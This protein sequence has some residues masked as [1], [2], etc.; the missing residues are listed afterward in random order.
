MS[1]SR[2]DWY[3]LRCSYSEKAGEM[4]IVRPPDSLAPR[5][6]SCGSPGHAPLMKMYPRLPMA[7]P[8]LRAFSCAMGSEICGPDAD[9]MTPIFSLC[10]ETIWG[11][12]RRGCS[13]CTCVI[14]VIRIR[15]NCLLTGHR[16]SLFRGKIYETDL[17]RPVLL[18]VLDAH[19]ERRN[20]AHALRRNECG[21]AEDAD[22]EEEEDVFFH[23]VIIITYIMI[24][25]NN[26]QNGDYPF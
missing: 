4:P 16:L 26:H 24:I 3:S 17:R 5:S 22:A 23:T 14:A 18:R 7:R 12:V 19:V 15:F 20:F 21:P 2:G 8:R 1:L 10:C 6:A 11:R 13:R 9:H 25:G